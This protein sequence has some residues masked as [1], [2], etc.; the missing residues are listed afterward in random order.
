MAHRL[1]LVTRCSATQISARHRTI[2]PLAAAV[3]CVSL[4]FS[5]CGTNNQTPGD[6]VSGVLQMVGGPPSNA[7]GKAGEPAPWPTTGVV[8]FTSLTDGR[9]YRRH[10]ESNGHL[11]LR[12]PADRYAVTGDP[13]RD[14]FWCQGGNIRVGQRAQRVAV[15]CPVV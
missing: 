3:V 9:V 5:A 12:L 15:N 13:G 10:T 2:G 6:L 11:Q 14:G 1:T 4:A 8:K 7:N